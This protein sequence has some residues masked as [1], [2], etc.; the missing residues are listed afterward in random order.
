MVILVLVLFSLVIFGL[1][2]LE[3]T[4]RNGGSQS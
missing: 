2:E 1:Q 4:L 3:L